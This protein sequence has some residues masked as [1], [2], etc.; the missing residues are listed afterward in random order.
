MEKIIV[1]YFS[2]KVGGCAIINSYRSGQQVI[3]IEIVKF[4]IV[5]TFSATINFFS[6]MLFRSFFPY[7]VSVLF[8]YLSGTISSFLL[9]KNYTFKAFDESGS[10][11][12]G[13]YL[14]V[15]ITSILLGMLIATYAVSIILS[16]ELTIIPANY[17][18]SLGHLIAI[19][20][21][22]I[23][24]YLA[25]KFFCFRKIDFIKQKL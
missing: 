1:W 4:L 6:R 19:G 23:Y 15:T 10:V 17:I 7:V 21:T 5:G 3:L 25:I 16:L 8:G 9:N 2:T 11:Q 18:E 13:K 12:F 22:T 24:N 20:L 14:I